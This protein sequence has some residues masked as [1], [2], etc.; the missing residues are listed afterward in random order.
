ML[1]GLKNLS[2]VDP[3]YNVN[4]HINIPLNRNSAKWQAR[5]G[6]NILK[7]KNFCY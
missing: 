4:K 6:F 2:P 3:G 5:L 7:H 1:N